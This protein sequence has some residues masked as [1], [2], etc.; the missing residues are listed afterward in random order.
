MTPNDLMMQGVELMLFGMGFVFLFL[1]LLVFAIRGMSV[2]IAR[3][4]PEPTTPAAT[5]PSPRS[6][7]TA[8]A[9]VSP[10]I[11]AAIQAAIHQHR[12]K[13]G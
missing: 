8:T 5:A 11:V 12:N 7:T 4:A 9:N 10:D 6:Q 2:L 1:T 3:F 13:R